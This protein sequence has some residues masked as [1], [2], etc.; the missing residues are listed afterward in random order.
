MFI[1]RLEHEVE[2]PAGRAWRRRRR[3]AARLLGLVSMELPNGSVDEP[4]RWTPTMGN[5]LLRLEANGS[6]K[7]VP[8]GLSTGGRDA[9]AVRK[10]VVGVERDVGQLPRSCTAGQRRTVS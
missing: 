6:Q 7:K 3:D 4:P 2:L 5:D 8:N 10:L 1:V 9:D